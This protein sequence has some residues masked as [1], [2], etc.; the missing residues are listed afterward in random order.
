[1]VKKYIEKEPTAF[2]A[3]QWTGNNLDEIKD[4][5]GKDGGPDVSGQV[6]LLMNSSGGSAVQEGDWIIR[7]PGTGEFYEMADVYF[8]KYYKEEPQ[9]WNY[10]NN[11]D[12]YEDHVL[13]NKMLA[14]EI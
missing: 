1:M 9:P 6:I 2:E 11:S 8:K 7:N 5:I 3:I 10:A 13:F 4:F 12:S 14:N